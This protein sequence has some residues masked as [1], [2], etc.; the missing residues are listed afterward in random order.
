[1][2]PVSGEFPAI[3]TPGL[4]PMTMASLEAICVKAFPHSKTRPTLFAG[5]RDFIAHA[6]TL[7]V[8]G[9]AWIDG[10][11]VTKK[12]DPKD[13]DLVVA[14]NGIHMDALPLDK[15]K[16]VEKLFITDHAHTKAIYGCDVYIFGEFPL[17]HLLHGFS[18]RWNTY[19]NEQF[20]F[21]RNKIAKGMASINIPVQP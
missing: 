18:G 17:I 5:L 2:P 12:P 14:G 4:H 16:L 19:W 1:M 13:C 10:S 3:L 11:F 9:Q 7:G 20:G 6:S 15:Q 21:D 8:Q